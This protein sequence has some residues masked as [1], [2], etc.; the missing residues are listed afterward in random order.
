MQPFFNR[1]ITATEAERT[2]FQSIPQI[3][4]A[5]A[6]NISRDAYLAFLVHA[7]HHV[8]HTTPLLMLTGAKLPPHKEWLR[9]AMAEYIAEEQG[10][11]EWILNDIA[12]AGG[13]KEAVRHSRPN[14]ATEMM[15]AYAY[16]YVARINPAGFLGMVFVLE[17]T[18]T[19]LAT[20]AAETLMH[21]L[22]LPESCFSYLTSHGSLDLS[23]MRFFEAL[24]NRLDAVD[25]E[26]VVHVAKRMFRLYGA[27]YQSIPHHK[28]ALE[29]RS[30]Q[31][32][33][34]EV[35]S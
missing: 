24:V 5:M 30:F 11:Q 4:D 15:V 33:M 28:L 19:A 25:Q 14:F 27:V 12:A 26:A 29:E 8:S 7:Y 17:G 31:Q 20:N 3:I 2:A 35:T 1:L 9:A 10:H 22:G 6:G 18:S 32:L 21:A 34:E 13:D 23:H 16:D